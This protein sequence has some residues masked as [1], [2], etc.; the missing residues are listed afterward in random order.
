MNSVPRIA[1]EH[2][3]PL[4]TPEHP[5]ERAAET[6]QEV[7]GEA[8]VPVPGAGTQASVHVPVGCRLHQRPIAGLACEDGPCSQADSV[9]INS[10]GWWTRERDLVANAYAPIATVE[11]RRSQKHAERTHISR[12]LQRGGAVPAKHG[13]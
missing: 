1:E 6:R 12:R 2:H 9:A 13:P 8:A 4:A 7:S 3:H 5:Q 11:S 10:T